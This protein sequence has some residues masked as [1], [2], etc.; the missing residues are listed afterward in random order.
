MVEGVKITV[1]GMIEEGTSLL[2]PICS[3]PTIRHYELQNMIY[4]KEMIVAMICSC[5]WR[6]TVI[7]EIEK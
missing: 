3:K 5:G 4:T 6:N 1:Y 7:L 2:C